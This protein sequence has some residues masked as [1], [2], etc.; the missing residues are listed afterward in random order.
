MMVLEEAQ[1]LT[2]LDN[3]VIFAE[4]RPVALAESGSSQFWYFIGDM[5]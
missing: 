5:F 1:S 4:T 3:W 2:S